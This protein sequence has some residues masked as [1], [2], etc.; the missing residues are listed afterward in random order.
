MCPCVPVCGSVQVRVSE[1]VGMHVCGCVWMGIFVRVCGCVLPHV[2]VC[3]CGGLNV[4]VGCVGVYV[5]ARESP[6]CTDISG[7][8]W[9]CGCVGACLLLHERLYIEVCGPL[10][11]CVLV[12][13]G[14]CVCVSLGV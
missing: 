3:V 8:M 14:C 4:C 1:R 5:R 6:V 9:L 12:L 13:G 10:R 11:I 7:N 2:C